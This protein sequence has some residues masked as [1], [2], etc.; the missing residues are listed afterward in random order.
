MTAKSAL[1]NV[2]GWLPYN[3]DL[4]I[5]RGCLHK[6]EYCFAMYSHKYLNSNDYFGDIFV[7]TNIAEVLEQDLK[8]R[9]WKH[10]RINI[11]GVC[12]SYQPLES[13]YKLMRKILKVLIKYKNLAMISTKSDLILR[14]FD[15][16]NKLSQFAPVNIAATI[17]T[18]DEDIRKLIEPN[19]SPSLDRFG[20]LKK[21]KQTNA[22]I[23][24]HLMPIL[25]LITDSVENL[26]K[27]FV[28]A[29][30]IDVDYVITGIL[31]LRGKTRNH[32]FNFLQNKFP[33]LYHKYLNYYPNSK[34]RKDYSSK[35]IKTLGSLKNKYKL[36]DNF[37]ETYESKRKNLKITKSSLDY[38]FSN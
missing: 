38:Y 26:E 8:K 22:N 9:S 5:Y 23:G 32:F 25:P 1:N 18:L 30:E 6:C 28:K 19:S 31:H 14:D 12:D 29:K 10:E 16:I 20:I 34:L 15:L 7:K 35:I 13:K 37:E 21:F 27:I 36:Y 11:G 33:E 2:S 17:T 3:W 24:L 4:N